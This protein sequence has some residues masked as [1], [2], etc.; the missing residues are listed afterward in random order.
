MEHTRS[1]GYNVITMRE[2]M[3]RGEADVLAEI[4]ETM[5]G[6]PVDLSWTYLRPV[7]RPGGLHADVGRG[8]QR[9][10][11]SGCRGASMD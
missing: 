7:R 8:P 4:Y 11:V 9:E 6:R 10:R 3:R 5:K 2:F 1:L